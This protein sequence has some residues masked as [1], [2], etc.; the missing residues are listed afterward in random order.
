[1]GM[2]VCVCVVGVMDA[3]VCGVSVGVCVVCGVVS[4]NTDDTTHMHT[5]CD[6]HTHTHTQNTHTQ[7][8]NSDTFCA[9]VCCVADTTVLYVFTCEPTHVVAVPFQLCVCVVC[10]WFVCVVQVNTPML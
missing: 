10:V 5:Q 8:T 1:M 3:R 9:E 6:T 2:C 4:R 7:H